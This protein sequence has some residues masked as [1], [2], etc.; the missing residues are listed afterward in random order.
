ME[1]QYT[2]IV[3]MAELYDH[4]TMEAKK[5]IVSRMI[6]RVD[7]GRGYDIRLTFRQEYRQFFALL[8]P[9]ARFF[10]SGGTA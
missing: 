10:R 4:A 5:M 7:V 6:E 1:R 9:S 2:Q 3:S 8:E